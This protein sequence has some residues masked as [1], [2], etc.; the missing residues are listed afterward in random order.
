MNHGRKTTQDNFA[1]Q[2]P[3]VIFDYCIL[4]DQPGGDY[5]FVPVGCGRSSRTVI[6]DACSIQRRQRELDSCTRVQR[7]WLLV[8]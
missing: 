3:E 2:A 4:R 7:S 8:Q 5:L 6:A 1:E